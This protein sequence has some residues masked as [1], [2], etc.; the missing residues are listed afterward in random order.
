MAT[1]LA[2]Q[3]HPT[4]EIKTF[5]VNR[6]GKETTR[7]LANLFDNFRYTDR[8]LEFESPASPDAV[9]SVIACTAGGRFS[10]A[11]ARTISM[12][13]VIPATQQLQY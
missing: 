1:I 3:L 9:S 5:V 12:S 7:F 13:R 8:N 2:K 10:E 6:L 4:H 11:G